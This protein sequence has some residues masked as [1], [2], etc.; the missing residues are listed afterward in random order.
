MML[1]QIVSS[2]SGAV[3]KSSMRAE[4]EFALI[5]LANARAANGYTLAV[6]RTRSFE[7]LPPVRRTNCGLPCADLDPKD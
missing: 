4:R 6:Y 1:L 5:R 2:I 3:L 7:L